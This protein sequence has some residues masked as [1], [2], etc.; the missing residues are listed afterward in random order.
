MS[1]LLTSGNKF[2]LVLILN[3]PLG[4]FDPDYRYTCGFIKAN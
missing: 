3:Q 1:N 4:Q 2:E